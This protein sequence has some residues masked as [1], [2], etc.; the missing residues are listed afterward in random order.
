[1]ASI[2]G[3]HGRARHVPDQVVGQGSSRSLADKLIGLPTWV[4]ARNGRGRSS[5]IRMR[6]V[7]QV[8]LGP[9]P[10]HPGQ[11]ATPCQAI[12]TQGV[13]PMIHALW[14]GAMMA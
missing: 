3:S 10:K 2:Y 9:L 1:M 11:P 8:H 4:A 12:R 5:L 6:S 13:S 7:V 14:P